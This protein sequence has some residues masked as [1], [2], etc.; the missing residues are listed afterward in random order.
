MTWWWSLGR[1]IL[2]PITTISRLWR[3]QLNI[4]VA[5]VGRSII[6]RRR[7]V[8]AIVVVGLLRR[9]VLL[10][11]LA[12]VRLRVISSLTVAWRRATQSP[13]CAAVGLVAALS[14]TT[15]SDASCGMLVVFK[16]LRLMAGLTRRGRR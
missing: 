8:V 11:L 9:L 1:L 2:R 13:A 14:A 3:L 10:L 7:W 4:V 12:I 16:S 15:G 5:S 6:V